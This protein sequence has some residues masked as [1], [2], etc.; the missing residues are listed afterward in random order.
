MYLVS[1]S[2]IVRPAK[3][4]WLVMATLSIVLGANSLTLG[5]LQWRLP[6]SSFS[7]T[8]TSRTARSMEGA[9]LTSFTYCCTAL[10][11]AAPASSA[12]PSW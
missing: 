5:R 8:T 3:E 1:A 12:M 6:C 10:R 11:A 2:G 4:R 7:G 9:I